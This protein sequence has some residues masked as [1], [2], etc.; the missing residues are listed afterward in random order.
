MPRS[1]AALRR[2]SLPEALPVGPAARAQSDQRGPT[3]EKPSCGD[4]TGVDVRAPDAS[5]P[6][7]AAGS[8]DAPNDERALIASVLRRDRKAAARLVAEHI[9]AVYG[10]ARSRLA[11]R[12]DLVDDVVQ[13]VFLAALNGLA[14][15][16]GQSSLRTWLLGIAR[17]KIEDV[18]RHRLRASLPMDGLNSPDVEPLSDDPPVDEQIDRTRA[19][20]KARRV[21]EQLPEHY[22]LLLSWRY[23]EQRS[24]RDIAAAMGTTEKSVER[25]LARARTRFKEMWLKES[26]H[27]R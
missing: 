23:W 16:Q 6:A 8:P 9:D 22:G 5:G 3:G 15:F 25:T 27:D 7:V 19:G 18:Y 11:P 2:V 14:T 21:L 20:E 10:F 12:A 17:H 24:T 26:G 13:E 4:N 1:S